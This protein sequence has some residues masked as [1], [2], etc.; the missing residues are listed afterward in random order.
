MRLTLWGGTAEEHTHDI[1]A[2]FAT[3]QRGVTFVVERTGGGLCG[4]I[5]VSLRDYV[6]GC[7]TSPVAY[8]EGWYVDAESRRH[9]LGTRLVQAAE[10][11]ARHQ[12]LK[13]IASDTQIENAVSIQAHKV[14]GY[15]EVERL[16]CFR[17]ALDA[18]GLLQDASSDASAPTTPQRREAGHAPRA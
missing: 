16:V 12:G 13:E 2:Y 9:R 6:E 17:K 1:D 4:F 5:E 15:E 8:I 3:P 11:W 7:T 10:A 14:L 18:S